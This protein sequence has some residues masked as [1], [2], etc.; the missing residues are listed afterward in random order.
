M[1]NGLSDVSADKSASRA[2]YSKP[3]QQPDNVHSADTR[4]R[5]DHGN[6]QGYYD[7]TRILLQPILNDIN[8]D[9]N[10]HNNLY[11]E[12]HDKNRLTA[13]IANS[14]YR[15]VTALNNAS[16]SFIPKVKSG[17][18]ELVGQGVNSVIRKVYFM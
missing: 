17:V 7:C 6:L 9:L 2:H 15:V 18:K 5:F 10:I 1:L 16:K 14:Y 3:S 12:N 8:D 13:V 11:Q 4:L